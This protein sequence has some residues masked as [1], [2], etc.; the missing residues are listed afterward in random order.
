MFWLRNKKNIFV[1]MYKLFIQQYS[2][3]YPSSDKKKVILCIQG[4]V[5]TAFESNVL[6]S[7]EQMV[8]SSK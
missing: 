2:Q 6:L 7:N 5:P 4:N 8:I 3:S 1:T